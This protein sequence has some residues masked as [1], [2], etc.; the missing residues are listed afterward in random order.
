[1]LRRRKP[2]R[3]LAHDVLRYTASIIDSIDGLGGA[4]WG[5]SYACGDHGRGSSDKVFGLVYV[6]RL[7]PD[8]G[9][10]V[11]TSKGAF[12][13]SPLARSSAAGACPTVSVE[14]TIDPARFPRPRRRP[15]AARLGVHCDLATLDLA[16]A[17]DDPAHR[18]GT[19]PWRATPSWGGVRAP[20]TIVAPGSS[21]S[22][23]TAP[24]SV[25]TEV[26][27]A[28]NPLVMNVSSGHRPA[29]VIREAVVASAVNRVREEHRLLGPRR[30][31]RV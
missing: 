12:P 22:P 20:R 16:T 17:F 2:L 1:V 6:A 30:Q 25:V 29:G 19:C 27:G 3:G 31:M 21:A 24:G 23:M 10:S 5:H 13:R 9:E 7:V 18:R 8:E 4:L 26:E 15:S 14:V 11:T 28:S